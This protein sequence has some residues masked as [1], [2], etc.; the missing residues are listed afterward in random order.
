[1]VEVVFCGGKVEFEDVGMLGNEFEDGCVW[2]GV[3]GEYSSS[4]E[5][6]G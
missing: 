2:E 4:S 5:D 3:L 1:M 6:V